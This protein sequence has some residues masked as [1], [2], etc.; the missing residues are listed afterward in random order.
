M[1]SWQMIYVWTI[2]GIPVSEGAKMGYGL[3]LDTGGTYTDAVIMD[4]DTG[5]VLGKAKSMTTHRDLSEGIR[6]A[7][8]G[9]DAGLLGSVGVVALS[10]TLATN[11]V[12]EGRGCRVGLVC[13]GCEYDNTLPADHT[14][15]VT[16]GH[17]IHGEPVQYLG[18]REAREFLESVRGKVEGIAISSFMSV[19]NPEHEIRVR[20]MA[21]EI[22]GVPAVCGF[23]LSSELGF[24]ERT[25]TCVMNARLIPVMDGLIRSVR[26]VLDE[27][28]IRAPLMISRG[29]GSMMRDSFAR[30]RPV[31]TILSGPAASLMGAMSMTGLGDAVVMDMGGTTT[32]IGILRGGRPSLDPEGTVIAGKRTRVMAARIYTSGIGGDSRIVVNP[33]RPVLTPRRAIP[34]CVAASRWPRA[35]EALE[36]LEGRDTRPLSRE[37]PRP[38]RA[39]LASEMLVTVRMPPEGYNINESNRRLLELALDGPVTI[40]EASERLGLDAS[41]FFLG[42]LEELGLI[43][44]IAFTPTDVLHVDG[45]YTE[46]DARASGMAARHLAALAGMDVDDF[47]DECRKA[48]R[49]KLCWELMHALISEDSGEPELGRTGTDLL[50]KAITGEHARD[51]RCMFRLDRPIVGIGAPSGVY[52]R[53]VGEMLGTEVVIAEDSDVGN[54]VGA[55]SA[56]VSESVRFRIGPMKP[57]EGTVYEAFSR[58]GRSVFTTMDEALAACEAQGREFVVRAAE[59]N[60]AECVAVTVDVDRSPYILNTGSTDLEEATLTVTAAGKP[61]MFRRRSISYDGPMRVTDS[62]RWPG[63]IGYGGPGRGDTVR[64]P[65]QV[66]RFSAGTGVPG[67]H[68]P[69]AGSRSH[70]GISRR[71]WP[72]GRRSRWPWRSSRRRR[73]RRTIPGCRAPLRRWSSAARPSPSRS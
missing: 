55:V 6:G 34:V 71:A 14:V 45:T 64:D 33:G 47:V 73:S 4:L 15:T 65:F 63:T 31:E 1:C 19:R 54:A 42:S 20:D 2:M 8:D 39:C 70:G 23:E 51:F 27:R 50:M 58:F 59:D 43:Q 60:N 22:L 41:E 40:G 36:S 3:G 46:F 26:T 56:S 69:P 48:I 44:R 7:I 57:V 38:W 61:R 25:T 30:E 49:T 37:D 32:D 24:N 16:G 10:S 18:E 11:S 52:I 72:R 29:D 21:R 62:E 17:G 13:I 68:G 12:V 66:T 5:R 35:R 28:G 9:L 67:P 53:W